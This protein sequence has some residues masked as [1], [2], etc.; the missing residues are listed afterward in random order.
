MDNDQYLSI[1]LDEAREMLQLLNDR[2]LQLESKPDDRK[3]VDEIFRA[4]HTLKGMSATMGYA[5][6]ADLTHKM[7]NLLDAIRVGKRQA[8]RTVVDALFSCLD[9]ISGMLDAIIEE[10]SGPDHRALAQ[11]LTAILEDGVVTAPVNAGVAVQTVVSA[12]D[13]GS[14][15]PAVA[16]YV[17]TVIL[18]GESQGFHAHWIEV[19]LAADCMLKGVRA[20]MVLSALEGQGELLQA[21]PEVSD[22][23]EERFDRSFS[24]LVL[25]RES[26]Q[27]LETRIRDVSEVASVRL[28]PL[29]AQRAAAAPHPVPVAPAPPPAPSPPAPA[30]PSSPPQKAAQEAKGDEGKAKVAQ[31]VRVATERLDALVNLVGEL[32]ID[33]TR[34][35]EIVHRYESDDVKEVIR[36][37]GSVISDIHGVIMKLRMMP[38]ERVFSRFPRMVRDLAREL[39]KE[40]QLVVEGQETELDRLMIDEIADPLLHLLRNAVDHGLEPGDDREL[41]GKPRIGTIRLAAR[42]EGSHVIIE[43]QDD[44]KGLDPERIRRKAVEKGL[45]GQDEA[46]RLNDKQCLD[47][48]FLPGF[49]TRDEVTDISGRGVG[50]DAVKAKT[51]ALGGVLDM[52]SQVGRG[53]HVTVILPLTLAII[54]CMLTEVG[55][56]IYAIPISFI[57]DAHDLVDMSLQS[58]QDEEM[59]MLRGQSLPLRR[60]RDALDVPGGTAGQEAS[61]VI[62]RVGS[63]RTGFLVDRLLG[64]QEVVIKPISRLA[65]GIGQV[66]G[67]SI[68][69]DGRIALI[70]DASAVA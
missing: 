41:M 61:V 23:E 57:E 35:Q 53:T 62:V 45:I 36:H 70:L 27:D 46:Q 66:S 19:T 51:L 16:D 40:V 24:L 39:G 25:S 9:T 4:A 5:A 47:L 52:T 14:G 43:V 55:E 37:V 33:R 12:A 34:L 18:E 54:Q 3:S 67:A 17:M 68:L 30:A 38:V 50:M 63:R 22:L 11:R 13:T 58:V 31:T 29:S 65:G 8:D 44:G 49:S 10:R 42:H 21:S 69:G 2:L 6:L 26:V 20:Y 1:F 64:Q 48:L 15:W 60:L 59:A 32:V 28:A 7:E 56:E